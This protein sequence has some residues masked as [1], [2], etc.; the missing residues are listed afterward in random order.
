MQQI[1]EGLDGVVCQMDDVLIWGTTQK[2]HD[3]MALTRLQDAGVTLNDKCEFSKS[4]IKFLGQ[5]IEA[6]G[7]SPDPHKIHAVKDMKEPSSVTEVRRFLGITNH[8]G[9]FLPHL[10]EKTLPLR[11]LLKK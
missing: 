4:K 6:T 3:E 7:V 11:E 9:K 2:E 8:L 10:A 1:L 5:I